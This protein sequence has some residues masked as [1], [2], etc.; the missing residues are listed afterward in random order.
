MAKILSSVSITKKTVLLIAIIVIE[1]VVFLAY[2]IDSEEIN[3][4]FKIFMVSISLSTIYL[5]L[6]ILENIKELIVNLNIK[7]DELKQLNSELE[8][9]IRAEV[10]KNKEK[11]KT[12]YQH[13]CLASMGEM[14]GNIAHQWRQPL[15]AMTVLIQSFA[16]K[17]MSGKL[18]N[19]FIEAQVKE[20]LRL[21]KMMSETIDN[22][23]NFFTPNR[24]KDYFDLRKVIEDTI[25]IARGKDINISLNCNKNIKIYGYQNEFSQVILNLLSNSIDSFDGQKLIYDKNILIDIKQKG[26]NITLSFIDNGGGIDDEIIDRIFGPYFTTK[27]KA[28]G[29]GIGLY[30]S[31]QIIEKQ[32]KGKLLASN[33]TMNFDHNSYKCAKFEITLPLTYSPYLRVGNSGFRTRLA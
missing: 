24:S 15:N 17:N 6:D 31:K 20:G 1:L 9:K 13:S 8:D 28:T 10:E 7:T 12:I 23:R 26:D 29:T 21:S 16:I 30:M 14:V 5:S 3:N 2:F 33:I 19:E 22:F 27:H 4:F 18:T 11:D 32:M 25:N